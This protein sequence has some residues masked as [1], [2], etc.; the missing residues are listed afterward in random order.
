[1]MTTAMRLGDAIVR[2]QTDVI[3]PA[4]TLVGS[5]GTLI[6]SIVFTAPTD[7]GDND[8]LIHD[9]SFVTGHTYA[10]DLTV[11]PTDIDYSE[12][13]L[14]INLSIPS[15][16]SLSAG[17][18]NGDGTWS[19]PLESNGS[20]LVSTD[21]VTHAIT[22]SG[23]TMTVPGEMSDHPDVTVITTIEDSTLEG[24]TDTREL[25]CGKFR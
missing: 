3:D 10:V 15:D 21:Q 23:L 4:M 19:L 22:I 8:Y 6:K 2:G 25:H 20:Y 12:S 7:G 9:I 11:A 1:M 18:S 24:V 13:V 16:A 17:T 5:G 14:S